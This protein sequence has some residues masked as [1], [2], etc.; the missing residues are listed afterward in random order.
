MSGMYY[1]T[2][3]QSGT[4]AHCDGAANTPSPI[5]GPQPRD[6]AESL[7]DVPG[8]YSGPRNAFLARFFAPASSYISYTLHIRPEVASAVI[9]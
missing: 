4:P 8:P 1:L 2:I 9:L 6:T 5:T 7:R 3:N